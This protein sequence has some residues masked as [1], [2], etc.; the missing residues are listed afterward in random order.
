[1]SEPAT[2]SA[3]ARAEA[4]LGWSLALLV[5]GA[6]LAVLAYAGSP[7]PFYDQWL[8][9]FNNLLLRIAGGHGFSALF[10]WHNEHVLFTTKLLTLSGFLANGYW[11]VAVLSVASAAIR[12]A[13][14]AWTFRLLAAGAGRGERIALWLLCAVAFV[15]PLSG[16]NLLSGLQASFYLTDLALLWSLRTT[17]RWSSALPSGLALGLGTLAGIF[18]MASGVVIPAA[19]L[20]AHLAERRPRPGFWAAWSVSAALALAYALPIVA[21]RLTGHAPP[22]QSAGGVL[23]FFLQLLAWP[24]SSALYGAL[25]AL[26]VATGAVVLLRSPAPVPGRGPILGLGVYALANALTIALNREPASFHMRHWDIAG[27]LP[28]A[29]LALGLRL[30]CQVRAAARPAALF[31]SAGTAVYVFSALALAWT[32]CRPYLQ[33]AHAR[34]D[35]VLVHYRSLLLSESRL[36][37]EAAG[38]NAALE[39]RDHSFFDDPI[40]RFALHPIVIHNFLLYSPSTHSLLAPEIVPIRPPSRFSR[41]VHAARDHG[42]LLLPAGALLGAWSIGVERRTV[43]DRGVKA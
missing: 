40:G 32:V 1:M 34:R 35:E 10:E 24:Q 27:L 14:A 7:L 6:R 25:L 12:A 19:T 42:W 3:P 20:A 36:R 13:A 9:E 8:A 22:D 39:R 26:L 5:A 28:L 18:S 21:D 23:I 37:A 29:A 38:L 30:A 11:D 15:T 4:R 33:A 17:L 41:L 2:V 43:A 31:V 16:Y